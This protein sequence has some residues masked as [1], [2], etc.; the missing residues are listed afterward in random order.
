LDD[1]SGELQAPSAGCSSDRRE[2][3][4][5]ASNKRATTKSWTRHSPTFAPLQNTAIILICTCNCMCVVLRS[6]GGRMLVFG[7]GPFSVGCRS[8]AL[9]CSLS[10]SRPRMR[11]CSH[12]PL[13][14]FGT[15]V[16]IRSVC[17]RSGA[18]RSSG[19]RQGPLCCFSLCAG[20]CAHKP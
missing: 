20:L 15:E 2:C 16:R 5:A 17:P 13:N 4:S 18:F 3:R 6:C 9:R 12:N 19:V 14:T 1:L 7:E 10:L 11:V 8:P